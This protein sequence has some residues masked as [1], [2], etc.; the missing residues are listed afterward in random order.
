MYHSNYIT[1]WKRKNY[2]GGKK[3]SGGEGRRWLEGAGE[4]L[5]AVKL[6]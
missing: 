2:G 3:I 1:F 4:M 5:K 6:F